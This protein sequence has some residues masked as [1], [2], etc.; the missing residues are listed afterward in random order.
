MEDVNLL[1]ML[2]SRAD[3]ADTV[4]AEREALKKSGAATAGLKGELSS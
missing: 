2:E 4:A 1:R 3:L